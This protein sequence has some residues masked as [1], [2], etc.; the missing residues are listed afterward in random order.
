MAVEH[1]SGSYQNIKVKQES[2][3]DSSSSDEGGSNKYR[4]KYRNKRRSSSSSEGENE[5]HVENSNGQRN[6]IKCESTSDNETK[7]CKVEGFT[8]SPLVKA[9]KMLAITTAKEKGQYFKDY[10][11]NK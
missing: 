7:S 11:Y 2:S 4:S 10:A 1:N 5:T 6:T 9:K 8:D 3:S